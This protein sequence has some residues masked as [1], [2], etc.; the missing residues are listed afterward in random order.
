MF[1]K[2]LK[3]F[4]R[5][6]KKVLV[7]LKGPPLSPLN[8]ISLFSAKYFFKIYF[9]NI[10]KNAFDTNYKLFHKNMHVIKRKDIFDGKV[11]KLQRFSKVFPNVGE[12]LYFG[13]IINQKSHLNHELGSKFTE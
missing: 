12:K 6:K 7:F 9:F 3:T 2:K 5:R 13:G 4:S 8:T 1:S 10:H 11:F